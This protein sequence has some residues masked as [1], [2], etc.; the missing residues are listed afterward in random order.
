MP[1]DVLKTER[2]A[3]LG[4]LEAICGVDAAPT[5]ADAICV[6]TGSVT[7]S[8][9]V[10]KV[11]VGGNC[12]SLAGQPFVNGVGR[13]TLGFVVDLA[14]SGLGGTIPPETDPL[15][16]ATGMKRTLDSSGSN[17]RINY[18]SD[19][20]FN[21]S[22][23]LYFN[24][25][26][27]LY[28]MLGAVGTKSLAWT[29]GGTLQATFE[30][31]GTCETVTDTAIPAVLTYDGEKPKV[32]LGVNFLFG[33][34]SPS[35]QEWSIEDGNTVAEL[36]D[37]NEPDGIEG[38]D[39]SSRIFTGSFS[40]KNQAVA[41]FDWWGHAKSNLD[42]AMSF[43]IGDAPVNQITVVCPVVQTEPPSLGED[44]GISS[45]EIAYQANEDM[46]AGLDTEILIR[47]GNP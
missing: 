31:T 28:R 9:S 37:A 47:F 35:I 7:L 41:S 29:V 25:D 3:V 16:I 5:G 26:G 4:K 1:L 23:T 32:A 12:G 44:D 33:A 30:F 22:I 18:E 11:E 14:S 42:S 36:Q 38:F 24:L 6:Q 21:G 46:S 15:W 20:S 34:F 8:D 39:V 2:H 13:R 40:V 17:A 27:Q 45:L 43:T 19:S 10:D